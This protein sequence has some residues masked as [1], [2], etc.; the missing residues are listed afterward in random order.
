MKTVRK[1]RNL[2]VSTDPRVKGLVE[3]RQPQCVH[4]I[5]IGLAR[6]VMP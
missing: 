1:R 5:Q 4:Q 2:D 6:V 3:H